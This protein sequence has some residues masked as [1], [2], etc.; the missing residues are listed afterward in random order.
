MRQTRTTAIFA[1][2][3][4]MEAL[5]LSDRIAVM[6]GGKILQIGSPGEVTHRPANEFIASFVGVETILTGKSD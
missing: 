1:T 4:R 3:D 2:H 5:R 6:K